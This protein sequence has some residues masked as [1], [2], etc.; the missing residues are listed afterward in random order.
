VSPLL[1]LVAMG[2]ATVGVFALGW[3]LAQG[4][5]R[6][7]SD[8]QVQMT[9]VPAMRGTQPGDTLPPEHEQLRDQYEAQAY[10]QAAQQADAT[11]FAPDIRPL[12]DTRQQQLPP[13]VRWQQPPVDPKPAGP[14]EW[15]QRRQADKTGGMQKLVAKW[16]GFDGHHLLDFREVNATAGDTAPPAGETNP[17]ARR[18]PLTGR[19]HVATLLVGVHSDIPAPVVANLLR[20]PLAG[21]TL[22]GNF[23]RAED[24]V[25]IE[26][27]RLHWQG[28]SYQV[29]AYAV[30]L[31]STQALVATHVNRRTLSRWA[32]VLGS[33]LLGGLQRGLL[34]EADVVSPGLGTVV[35]DRE[36]DGE[37]IAGI[38]VGEIGRRTR[39]LAERY[40]HRPNTITVEEA[41]GIV[42]L[43]DVVVVADARAPAAPPPLA[44]T[45]SP[46]S[47]PARTASPVTAPT[48]SAAPL[49]PPPAAYSTV[50]EQGR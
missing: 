25:L 16:I 31:D 47:P 4:A 2:L 19:I 3:F 44:D 22:T 32:A 27:Q 24:G 12:Q 41:V 23:T 10:Q 9:P 15:Q 14:S 18:L 29:D 49:N 45:A 50:P 48:G 7:P 1:K 30:D 39:P 33:A 13:H 8:A 28:Q 26:F 20:P 38:A 17:T 5:W 6:S 11:S 21:A 43:S 46:A 36:L 40:W 42:F 34:A 35:I 37:D